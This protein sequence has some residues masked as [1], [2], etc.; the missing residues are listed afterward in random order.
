M[1]FY[2]LPE[3]DQITIDIV[4]DFRIAAL[5]SGLPIFLIWAFPE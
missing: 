4:I 5:E 2:V 1:L 3:V